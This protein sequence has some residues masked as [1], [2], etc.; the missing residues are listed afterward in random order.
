MYLFNLLFFLPTSLIF[1]LILLA[2]SYIQNDESISFV[3][4]ATSISWLGFLI[5]FNSLWA[6]QTNIAVPPETTVM[7]IDK[8]D[9][10]PDLYSVLTE[11]DLK[12]FP[13]LR[14]ALEEMEEKGIKSTL[15]K[16]PREEGQVICDYLVTKQSGYLLTKKGYPPPSS[17]YVAQFK[18]NGK[19][20]GFNLV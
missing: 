2:I 4:T 14:K 9:Y 18:Y 5:A 8:L 15:Y 17:P 10:K 19:F 7:R 16:V 20:Y 13:A 11:E 1:P 6:M 12:E 3:L